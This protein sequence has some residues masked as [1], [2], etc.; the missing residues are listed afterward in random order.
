MITVD[1]RIGS[2]ELI[3]ILQDLAQV[4]CR[5]KSQVPPPVTSSRL[6]GGD[7]CFDGLG[8]SSKRLMIGIERKRLRDMM[9]SIRSGRYSGHQLPEML[10]LY[11]QCYL[12]IEGHHRCGPAG[13][14]EA[15]VTH[16][17][18]LGDTM[19][20]KWVPVT[21]GSTQTFRYTELDHF[22][23]TLEQMTRVRVRR[24]N[25][26][27]ETC[28]Q[29]LSL[30]SHY[31][32]PYEQHHSHEAMHVPQTLAT[33]GKAGLVR[34]WAADLAGIGWTKSGA[35]A[36]KFQTGLDL[37]NASVEQWETIKPGIGKVMAKRC[38]EQIRGIWREKGE[39]L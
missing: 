38:W 10:D 28:A 14:L 37:A 1:D 11:D 33:L 24:T 23:C 13:E 7:I 27:Y 21:C 4:L 35:V 22:C 15:L 26:D 25:T 9:N 6:L 2:I 16:A 12:I 19:G 18:P 17:H 8:P 36:N 31:Q 39:E 29:I 34:K 20:G 5:S 32:K 30:Y 3:P